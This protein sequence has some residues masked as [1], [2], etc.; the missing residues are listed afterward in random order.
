MEV[1]KPSFFRISTIFFTGFI[2]TPLIAPRPNRICPF[3]LTANLYQLSLTSGP[4]TSKPIRLHSSMKKVTF[5]MSFILLL[6]TDAI[7]SAG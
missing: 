6:K 4:K 7:Y 2:P 1:N 5:L 3:G